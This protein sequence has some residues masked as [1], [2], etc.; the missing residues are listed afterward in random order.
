V[1]YPYVRKEINR[2]P[3]SP[4]LVR[5]AVIV[6]Y[7]TALDRLRRRQRNAAHRHQARLGSPIAL[8]RE[9]LLSDHAD[10]GPYGLYLWLPRATLEHFPDIPPLLRND[11][12]NTVGSIVV[13]NATDV[14]IVSRLPAMVFC[15]AVAPMQYPHWT[16]CVVGADGCVEAPQRIDCFALAKWITDNAIGGAKS[17]A[18]STKSIGPVMRRLLGPYELPM[19]RQ[20][21][22]FILA[23]AMALRRVAYEDSASEAL[24]TCKEGESRCWLIQVTNVR[25]EMRP[26]GRVSIVCGMTTSGREAKAFVLRGHEN[27]QVGSTLSLSYRKGLPLPFVQRELQD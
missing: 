24:S 23:D 10:A 6:A 25:E 21:V 19:Y 27:I 14:M 17:L 22:P 11:L 8:W 16:G 26:E 12:D 13:G 3:G 4:E 18:K 20:C 2:I 7:R 5:F 9:Y 15:T 1:F